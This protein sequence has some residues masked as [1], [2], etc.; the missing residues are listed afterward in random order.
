MAKKK[1]SMA[2]A[3]GAADAFVSGAPDMAAKAGPGRPRKPE[4]DYVRLNVEI[5][6]DLAAEFKILAV[7]RGTTIKDLIT[8]LMEKE[9]SKDA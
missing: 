8:D 4:G 1:I 2:S 5:R 3:A 9:V 7:R 6:A